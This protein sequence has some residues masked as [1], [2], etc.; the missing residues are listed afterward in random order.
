MKQAMIRV[1]LAVC[2][3]L[4][5]LVQAGDLPVRRSGLWEMDN[6]IEGMP[7]HGPIQICID[8]NAD[9]L[10]EPRGR[11][12]ERNKP[13]CSAIDVKRESGG[14]THIHT[15]CKVDARTTATTDAVVS[16][17]FG[18][19]YRS[20]MMV[21]Y[22]PPLE[23]MAEMRMVSQGKWLGPCKPGQRHG[24]VSMPGMPAMPAM[25]GGQRMPQEMMNDPRLR[26]LM[27][28]QGQPG[29]DD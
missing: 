21:H 24:D 29:Q 19:A 23:G 28:R 14:R 26:E 8:Q 13:D 15:V 9:N 10:I 4:G 22:A 7:A 5:C 25:P 17:D 11:P 6:R 12:G 27:K 20:E 1:P 16:G 3:L 2:L 18:K